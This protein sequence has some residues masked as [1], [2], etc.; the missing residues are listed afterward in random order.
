MKGGGKKKE[1]QKVLEKKQ[2]ID[3]FSKKFLCALQVSELA[4]GIIDKIIGE[5]HYS[6]LKVQMWTTAIME[7]LLTELAKLK[8]PFKYIINCSLQQKTG[9]GLHLA[10]ASYWDPITD[11]SCTVK[12]DNEFVH[13]CIHVFGV[14][15]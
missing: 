1:E 13:C 4:L 9:A 3:C 8:R 5:N 15:I 2:K 12:W 6:E 7:R 11:N 10:S 14:Q